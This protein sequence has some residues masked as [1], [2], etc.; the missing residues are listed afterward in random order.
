MKKQ[1]RIKFVDL[2]DN[3]SPDTFFLYKLLKERYEVILSDTPD[4]VF[5]SVFGNE[6]LNYTDSVLIFWTG[7]NQCPDFNECDYAIGFEHLTFG[8]RYLRYP[9]YLSFKDYPLILTKHQVDEN[10]LS[11]KS[12]F[13]SFVYSNTNASPLR[14]QFYDLLSA[15]KPISSGGKYL[16]NIGGSPVP[17]KLVFEQQAKF[18]IAFENASHSGYTTEKIMQ[19]FAAGTVPVYWGDPSVTES[20]N[21]KSFINCQDYPSLEAVVEEIK[22]LDQDDA[23]YLEMLRRPAMVNPNEKQETDAQLR[24]FLYNIFDQ[25][26]S[27]A[28]R[29]SRD[30]WNAHIRLHRKLE[31]RAYNRSLRGLAANFYRKHLFA[32]SRKSTFGW[33]IT[34]LLMKVFNRA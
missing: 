15:Y 8:D 19:S 30:Y 5:Y 21:A 31:I 11:R 34:S 3:F 18:S 12:L 24:R 6:H 20:F 28:K 22:R 10:I 33:K 4:Y 16:N 7:E 29:F 1:I 25:P 23:A 14:K 13:C 2:F 9:L 26:L 32:L 27:E 17:D